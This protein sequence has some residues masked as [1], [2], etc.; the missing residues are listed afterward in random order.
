MLFLY[1][2]I[3]NIN[4]PEIIKISNNLKYPCIM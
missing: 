2:Y 1:A 3:I 4:V